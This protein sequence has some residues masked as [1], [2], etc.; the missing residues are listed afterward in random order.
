MLEYGNR[1]GLVWFSKYFLGVLKP[2]A[3]TV[4]DKPFDTLTTLMMANHLD[5]SNVGEATPFIQKDMG[6]LIGSPWG[7]LYSALDEYAWMQPFS[8]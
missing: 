6:N 7:T 1:V 2:L 8:H 3:Q 5:L 4:K